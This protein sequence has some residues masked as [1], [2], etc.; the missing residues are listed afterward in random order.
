MVLRIA[1]F[2]LVLALAATSHVT[3]QSV[4]H[5][6]S[7]STIASQAP[8]AATAPTTIPALIRYSGTAAQ[9]DGKPLSGES[10]V[11]FYVFKDQTGG[12]PLWAESQNV[13]F[14]AA[15][16]YEIFLGATSG[17]GLPTELFAAGE[18]RWLEVQVAGQP[19]QPRTLLVSVPYAMKAADAATLGG[20]PASAFALAGSTVNALA[21]APASVNPDAG[22]A[23]T[24]T[25]GTSGYLPVYSGVST[26]D[27]SILFQS[28]TKLGINTNK[29]AGALDV[30]GAIFGRGLFTMA[31]T[32]T[33]TSSAGKVSE[34]IEFTASAY[35]SSKKAAVTPLFNLQAEPVAN[36]TA[37]PSATL[38]L[39]YGNGSTPAETGFSIN[40]AGVIKFAPGQTFPSTSSSG[41]AVS[42]ASTSGTGVEGPS[43]TGD[44]MVGTTGGT[45]LNRAGVLGKAGA[46]SGIT[47]VAAG[48]WGDSYTQVGVEGTSHSSVGVYGGS[49]ISTGVEGVSSSGSGVI[50]NTAGTTLNTAGTVGIA[51]ARDTSGFNG[52]AGIWGDASAHVGVWGSSDQYSGVFGQSASGP[53]VQGS[54]TKGDGGD[55]YGGIN[56]DVG[57][58]G[59][60]A[61]GATV[62]GNSIGGI[63]GVFYG[64]AS[65]F[66]GHGIVTTGGQGGSSG[67]AGIQATGGASDTIAG[68]GGDFFGSGS[69]NGVAGNGVY[70]TE[71]TNQ[72]NSNDN[73]YAGDFY[74]NVYVEGTLSAD[75]KDFK[76]DHPLDPA[77]KYLSH[78]S[79]ESSEMINVYSGNVVT[80]EFGNAVIQL[81]TWF[82][83]LNGDLRY[84]LTVIGRKAQ[85]WVA[86]E[87]KDGV[88]RI[89]SDANRVKVSWQITGVRHD[90]YAKAHPLVV[91][92]PKGEHERGFYAHPELYGQLAEKQLAWGRHPE[93]MRRLK[94]TNA[95]KGK[96]STMQP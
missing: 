76:I 73:G 89:S 96:L 3:G 82:D 71:G 49:T 94:A 33:A 31:T 7:V 20:L 77:N 47:S 30:N 62:S 85:A 40:S 63:G 80:D 25:G 28:G 68:D 81:P 88:F 32:G 91:E 70:A 65:Y 43:S 75:A 50:G 53:G 8:P 13:T 93:M 57:A 86:Q 26:I 79:V 83:S 12:E 10:L 54:S 38:N 39:L 4:G 58:Y 44:G 2:T 55:F 18:A 9:S 84:Q 69:S 6:S 14:D 67:G 21:S 23:V 87:A 17:S 48:V 22:T 60:K 46:V 36:N 42:G 45:T 66:A 16:G 34:A 51:G 24:T 1:T 19:Q 74:G 15:G 59:V 35:N 61:A 11:N 41:I 27:D 5:N 52:I 90:A 95:A 29:P 56:G 72:N 64:G 92:E 37:G 78:A